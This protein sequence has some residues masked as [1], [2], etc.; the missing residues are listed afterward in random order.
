MSKKKDELKQLF[1][2]WIAGSMRPFQIVADPGFKPIVRA[3]I[4]TGKN[5]HEYF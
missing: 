1:T 2:T 5:N 3:C 4:D